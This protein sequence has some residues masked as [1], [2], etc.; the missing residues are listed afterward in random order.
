MGSYQNTPTNAAL[1]GT[2]PIDTPVFPLLT[3]IIIEGKQTKSRT[4]SVPL[5]QR[6]FE[7]CKDNI[8]AKRCEPTSQV[9]WDGISVKLTEGDLKNCPRGIVIKRPKNDALIWFDSTI[10][11]YLHANSSSMMSVGSFEIFFKQRNQS[12]L[13]TT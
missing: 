11:P 3:P 4:G 10:P 7:H 9:H 13:E 2:R 5:A 6:D 1:G 12:G 8:C